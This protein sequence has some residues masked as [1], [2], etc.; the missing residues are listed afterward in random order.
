MKYPRA[1]GALRQAPDPMLK[2]ARFAHTML[3]HTVGNLGLSRSGGSPWSNPGSAP[4]PTSQDTRNVSVPWWPLKL[5][6]RDSEVCVEFRW[7]SQKERFICKIHCTCLGSKCNVAPWN[8]TYVANL[9]EEYIN[10][11]SKFWDNPHIIYRCEEYVYHSVV[12]V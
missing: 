4:D 5:Y 8:K 1:T 7:K 9:K 3:L 6:A 12:L 2:R 10:P 11:N